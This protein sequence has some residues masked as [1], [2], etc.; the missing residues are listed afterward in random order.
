MFSSTL[1][2]AYAVQ[3]NDGGIELPPQY[4]EALNLA[5]AMLKAARAGDWESVRTL[6][7]ALPGLAKNLEESWQELA[8]FEP[9]AR[10][11]LEEK[12]LR[13][14]REILQVDEQIRQLSSPAYARLSPRL[15]TVPMHGPIVCESV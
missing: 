9:D 14:I 15:Q 10:R 4:Q 6:R 13:M 8:D 5:E 3:D 1:A 7:T 12:R 2:D 11:K